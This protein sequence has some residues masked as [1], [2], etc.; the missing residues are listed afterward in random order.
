M[1]TTTTSGSTPTQEPAGTTRTP[2]AAYCSSPKIRI[3]EDSTNSS[4]PD[5]CSSAAPL[6]VIGVRR[7]LA[8]SSQRSSRVPVTRPA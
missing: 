5:A 8:R 1:P 6:G 3:G 7:S 4:I 2:A